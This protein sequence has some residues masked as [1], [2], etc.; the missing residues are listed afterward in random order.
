MATTQDGFALAELDLSL[1]REGDVTG[2]R[3]HGLAGLRFS[4]VIRDADLIEAARDDA[5]SI[6]AKDPTLSAPA[7]I[8]LAHELASIYPE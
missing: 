5:R 8:L 4:N 2:S 6:L 3:Q 7:N 1:R